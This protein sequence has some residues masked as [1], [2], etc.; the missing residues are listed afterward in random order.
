LKLYLALDTANLNL[1]LKKLKI[2][3]E[4]SKNFEHKWVPLHQWHIPLCPLGE[5][6]F[7]S[8]SEIQNKLNVIR[9]RHNSFEIKLD[10]VWAYPSQDHGRLLWVGVQNVKE[11]RSLQEDVFSEFN[12]LIPKETLDK[13]FKPYLPIVR[14]RNYKEVSDLL[15]PHKNSHFGKVRINKIIIYEMTSQG[16]FPVYR[17]LQEFELNQ[18]VSSHENQAS[19]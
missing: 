15:S 17:K 10:G 7:E 2:N 4:K 18:E 6:E 16:A 1:D 8:L 11:L 12:E 19:Y 14:F 5:V 3:L 13:P 9:I